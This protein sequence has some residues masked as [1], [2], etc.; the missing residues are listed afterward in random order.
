MKNPALCACGGPAGPSGR[1]QPC[2]RRWKRNGVTDDPTQQCSTDGCNRVRFAK[3][4][5]NGCYQTQWARVRFNRTGEHDTVGRS[6]VHKPQGQR[7]RARIDTSG[8]PDACH[9]WTGTTNDAGYAI[10]RWNGRDRRVTNV[11]LEIEYGDDVL[12]GGKMACHTCDRP[13]CCNIKHLYAGTHKTNSDDSHR[14]GRASKPPTRRGEA[15][16]A[17]KLTEDQVR[18]M[19][20]EREGGDALAV[21]VERYGVSKPVASK[22]CRYEIWTHIAPERAP[23]PAEPGRKLTAAD[24]RTLRALYA[25]GMPQS[26]LATRYG[27]KQP[28]VSGIV[29]RRRWSHVA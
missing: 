5:C 24:V 15:H 1:C 28:H 8:G 23:L 3:G 19:R 25:S 9:D 10:I 26:E 7:L 27:I 14:R 16:H 6:L 29:T 20:R 12:D 21:L 4:W 13:P 17:A 11:L 2:Y 22:I 18:S